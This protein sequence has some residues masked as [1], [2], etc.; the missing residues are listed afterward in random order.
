MAQI[1]ELL[2]DGYQHQLRGQYDE[3]ARIYRKI[4]RADPGNVDVLVLLGLVRDSQFRYEEAIEHFDKAIRLK[5]GSPQAHYNRGVALTKLRRYPEAVPAFARAVALRPELPEALGEYALA[6]RKIC[7]WSRHAWIDEQLTAMVRSGRTPVNPQTMLQFSDDPADLLACARGFIKHTLGRNPVRRRMLRPARS[8]GEKIRLA[9]LSAD[10]REHVV[11][12]HIAPLI[13]NHDRSRFEVIGISIGPD[14]KSAMRYRLE[15]GFDQIIDCFAANDEVAATSILAAGIDVLVDLMGF[16]I[17]NRLDLLARGLAPIQV[18]FVGYP[19]TIGADFIDY[20]LADRF[21]LPDDAQAFYTEQI[22]RLPD[23]YQPNDAESGGDSALSRA[24]CGLPDTGFVFCSFNQN[25]KITPHLFDVWMRL[26]QR[27]PESVLWLVSDSPEAERNLQREADAR[28]VDPARLVFAHRVSRAE[29]LA[30]LACADLFLDTF[31]W[32][33]HGTASNALWAGLPIVTYAG[34]SLQTRV[35][36]SLLRTIGLP[37]LVTNSLEEYEALAF[38][39]ATEPKR[40]ADVKRRLARNR[41][42][43]PLF[44]LARYTRHLEAA[45]EEMIAI[46]RRGEKPRPI[47]VKPIR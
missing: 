14:D 31:P 47:A 45:Y 12:F 28:R 22:V 37:E 26:L 2:Y 19:G 35:A 46:S 5:P 30:R 38:S 27:V 20:V 16:T 13:E 9:Y 32:N 41:D 4:L 1:S 18:D 39:L 3:A 11:A 29:Y 43:A 34:R 17:H 36:G 24:Q 42:T 40:L 8:A 6:T 7:D 10:F 33:A 15:A 23:C 21:V 25:L 44:D